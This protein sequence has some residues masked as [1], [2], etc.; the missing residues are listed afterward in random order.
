[1]N[2]TFNTNDEDEFEDIPLRFIRGEKGEKGKDGKDGENGKDG[3]NISIQEIKKIIK[4]LIPELKDGKDG[5]TP[6]EK[7]LLKIIKPLIPEP[8]EGSPDSPDEV[9]DKVNKAKN[10]IKKNKIEGFDDVESYA[11]S[12][13][14]KIQKY[15]LMGGSTLLKIQSNGSPVGDASTLNFTNGT[16]TNTGG[17]INITGSGGVPTT[18]NINTTAPLSGGGDL[19]ADRTL[20]TSMNT[21]KLIGRGSASTGVMEEITLG[22][23]LSFTG[24]TLNASG[25]GMAIGSAVTS[26]TAGSVLFVDGSGNLGQDNSNFFWDGTNHRLGIGTT[27][28]SHQLDIWSATNQVIIFESNTTAGNVVINGRALGSTRGLGLIGSDSQNSPSLTSGDPANFNIFLTSNSVQIGGAYTFILNASLGLRHDI[29]GSTNPDANSW[30]IWQRASDSWQ[31]AAIGPYYGGSGYQGRLSFWT[32]SGANA[33]DISQ[34]MVLDANGNLGLGVTGTTAVGAM[35]SINEKLYVTSAGLVTKYNNVSTVA[36]G[37][38]AIYGTGR[39]TAQTGA[40][41]SVATYTCGA[42]DGS[43][44]ISAN[45][46]ITTFVAGTFNVTVAYTDETNTAQTLKL[47]FASLTGTLGVSLAAAG[48]FEGI[49]NHIRC[50]ASTAITIATSGTF[51]S[52]TYNVEGYITQIG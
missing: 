52:L 15:L 2:S 20:T 3:K 24:T 40:V 43:F 14:D 44:L 49:P 37:V 16:V 27:A 32:N 34:K 8:K 50:K 26:G 23:N 7:Q 30:I 4:P 1:M 19:S 5:E 41:A 21:N 18:R 17:T 48:P 31:S 45:A 22:T 47:N 46:N 12:A 36:G 9:I 10:K 29:G 25:G 38:P 28:P 6:S 35:L 13:N 33:S 42:A 39:S 51:T 11:R